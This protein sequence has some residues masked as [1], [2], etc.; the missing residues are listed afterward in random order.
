M[1][2]MTPWLCD[3]CGE[4]IEAS[5]THPMLS[6]N[7]E[8]ADFELHQSNHN[9]QPVKPAGGYVREAYRTGLEFQ[10][11]KGFNPYRFGLISAQRH[12]IRTRC[13]PSPLPAKTSRTD[14]P[15]RRADHRPPRMP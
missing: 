9:A 13:G 14:F 11:S 2:V 3:E 4:P 7:D 15:R 6:P 8:F 5:E 1:K 12:P 10:D